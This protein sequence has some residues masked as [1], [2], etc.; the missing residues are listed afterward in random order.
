MISPPTDRLHKFLAI[1]GLAL[2]LSVASVPL[3]KYQEAERQRIEA[4]A[5]AHE[6]QFTYQRYADQVN[7]MIRIRNDAVARGLNGAELEKAKEKVQAMDPEAEKLGREM[8]QVLV[9]M[10]RLAQLAVHLE[11]IKRVWM[12]LGFLGALLGV[13]MAY[14]GFRQ[15][16]RLPQ[17]ER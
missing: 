2:L 13:A 8:E 4:Y 17:H 14:A 16:L 11:W 15:W 6:V 9:E 5:K 1:G 7:R 12:W 3:Q 10:V